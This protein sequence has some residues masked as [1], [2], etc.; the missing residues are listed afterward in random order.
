MLAGA[1]AKLWVLCSHFVNGRL[2]DEQMD[3]WMDAWVNNRVVNKNLK[4]NLNKVRKTKHSR[5][6]K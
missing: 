2:G 4:D 5:K 3:Q 6:H 1:R